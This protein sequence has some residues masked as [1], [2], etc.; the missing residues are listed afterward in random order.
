MITSRVTERRSYAIKAATNPKRTGSGTRRPSIFW[1]PV[2][3]GVYAKEV[4]LVFNSRAC[5]EQGVEYF[6]V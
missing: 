2:P 3:L 1:L 6:H 5:I 4:I